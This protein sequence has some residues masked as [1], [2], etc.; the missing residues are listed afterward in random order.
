M[1][2]KKI[3]VLLNIIVISIKEGRPYT[4]ELVKVKKL[5]NERKQNF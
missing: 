3:I 5:N 4:T 2:K 1:D